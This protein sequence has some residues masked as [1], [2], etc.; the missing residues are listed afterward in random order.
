MVM[1]VR[2]LLAL[3]AFPVILA[4]MPIDPPRVTVRGHIQTG[5]GDRPAQLTLVCTQGNGGALTLQLWLPGERLADF[6][7]D[8]YEGPGAPAAQRASAHLRI[9]DQQLPAA[10]VGGWYTSEPADAPMSFVF[11]LS[12]LA[13]QTGTAASAA[14]ALGKNGA[15]LQW[16]QDNPKPGGQPLNASFS[17]SASESAQ[18][19]RI[20]APCLPRR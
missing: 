7:L 12:R 2:P 20:T 19:A 1:R 15:T 9:G 4:A 8:A 3:L 6:D 5:Q 11:G 13:R 14:R 10:K 18:I 17:P 16:T